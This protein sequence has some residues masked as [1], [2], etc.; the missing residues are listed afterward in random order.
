MKVRMR[1]IVFCCDGFLV[2]LIQLIHFPFGAFQCQGSP[3]AAKPAENTPLLVQIPAYSLPR[4]TTVRPSPNFCC[5]WL[6]NRTSTA[7]HEKQQL[8]AVR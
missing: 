6:F 2:V 4:T 5:N 7:M 1:C 8:E 3:L